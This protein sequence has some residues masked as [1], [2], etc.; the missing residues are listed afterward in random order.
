[1]KNVGMNGIDLSTI[2]SEVIDFH[3]H[4]MY[5][6]HLPTHGVE[7]DLERF[8][9]D[10]LANGITHA[11]G[12]VIYRAMND[13]PLEEYEQIIP[14]LNDQ[15]L[16]CREKLGDFYIPGIHVHPAFGELSCR[17]IERCHKKGVRLIGELVPYMMRWSEYACKGFFEIM[18]YAAELGMVV[19]MHPS[20]PR[21][22][23]AF[24]EAMPKL[25]IVWA[26]FSAY[27]H[28]GDHM[29]LLRRFENVHF[30][31]S[32]HGCDFDGTLRRA[33]DEVG[34]GRLLFGTDYPGINPASDVAAV[35]FEPL[36]VR[37]REAIL[38]GNARRVLE[39]G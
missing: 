20:K 10:L 33:V 34:C 23:L 18:E 5:D 25:T 8:K 17:E 9:N 12:S 36:S 19:N 2:G 28:Y 22:M 11:C 14:M 37:E 29:E 13:C 21:D 3:T 27:G 30:D 35:R 4:P 6:F 38:C 32:A 7:I 39:M 16:K 15:A 26:H 1:M 24:S 31:I